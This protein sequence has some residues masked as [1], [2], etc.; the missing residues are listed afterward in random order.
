MKRVWVGLLVV[1]FCIPASVFGQDLPS[2]GF[3]TLSSL[4][5]NVKVNPYAQVGFQWVG[6]NLNL[7][8]QNEPL[9]V[10]PLNIGSL[11]ISLKDANFWTGIAGITIIANDKYS[12]F[13]TAGGFLNRPFITSGTVPVS[14]DLISTSATLEF[15]NTNV[16]SWFIQTGIGLGPV[17]FGLYWDHFAFV[18]GEPRNQNG[19]IANQTLRGDI[20]TRTFAPFI[21]LTLPVSGAML[22]VTYSPFAYSNTALA[23]MNSQNNLSELRYTWK[24]P[25]DL[26]NASLQYNTPI[27]STYQF[28]IW[29][30]YS[31]MRLRRNAELEFQ[32]TPAPAISRTRDVT[33]TMTKYILGGGVNVG[34]NF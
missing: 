27:A 20:L 9:P 30:N 34:I 33:A 29:C 22:T 32:N 12:L 4:T 17:L 14:L 28:G 31:W 8:V 13:G 5:E 7:P 16:E 21:G 6:S 2:V 18:L 10:L 24:K 1:V 19:P 25:G 3:P 23:L 11:D 15:D 26:L